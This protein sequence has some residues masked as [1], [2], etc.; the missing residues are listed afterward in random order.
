MRKLAK[1]TLRRTQD[2]TEELKRREREGLGG[3]SRHMLET[4]KN[5]PGTYSLFW[6]TV[7]IKTKYRHK[8]RPYDQKH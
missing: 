7:G 5:P 2:D 4:E 3:K 8:P 1:T 6:R